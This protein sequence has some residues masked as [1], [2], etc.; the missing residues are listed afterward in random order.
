MPSARIGGTTLGLANLLQING[1]NVTVINASL[2]TLGNLAK[3]LVAPM[4]NNIL[5]AL[6]T[7]LVSEISR[8]LGLN[9]G[10]A[11]ITPQWMDC[12]DDGSV[13]LVE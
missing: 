1:L 10:G 13:T 2:P 5:G 12:D 8:L 6:D 7:L 9:L 3:N 11:D 4:L